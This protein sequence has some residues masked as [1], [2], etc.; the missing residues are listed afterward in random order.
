MALI[1]LS[2]PVSREERHLIYLAILRHSLASM[3]TKVPKTTIFF[4]LHDSI[5]ICPSVICLKS[6]IS[7]HLKLCVAVAR[8]KFK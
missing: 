8:D 3:C 1:Y 2:N 4:S 5:Y 7:T 6:I